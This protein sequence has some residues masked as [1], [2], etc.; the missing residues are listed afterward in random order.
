MAI[1]AETEAEITKTTKAK[2]TKLE[3]D[4]IAN[5]DGIVQ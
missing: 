5:S 1:D 4:D 3:D 2:T